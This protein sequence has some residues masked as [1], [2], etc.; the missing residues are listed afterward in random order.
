MKKRKLTLYLVQRGDWDPEVFTSEKEAAREVGEYID[1][2]YDQLG[3]LYEDER[4]STHK[5]FEQRR[6]ST[7]DLWHEQDI[8][9]PKKIMD[10][11]LEFKCSCGLFHSRG[12]CFS[13]KFNG[14]LNLYKP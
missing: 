2:V 14:A 1:Y 7:Q 3:E 13:I 9:T 4:V 12:F 8:F 11:R 10:R 5:T 6:A